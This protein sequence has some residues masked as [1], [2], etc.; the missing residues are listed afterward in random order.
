MR[1]DFNR[2]F[3]IRDP[4]HLRAYAA[5]SKSGKWPEDF[6][7]PQIIF[8]DGWQSQIE[9]QIVSTFI[10]EKT[11]PVYCGQPNSALLMQMRVLNP[12]EPIRETKNA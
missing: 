9:Q 6:L 11:A 4:E 2:W 1:T 10:K 5:F 3:N 8:E 12:P 7:P